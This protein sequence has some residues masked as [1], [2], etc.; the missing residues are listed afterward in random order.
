MF[1]SFQPIKLAGNH[2]AKFGQITILHSEICSQPDLQKGGATCWRKIW[3][4]V[5]QNSI[6]FS[7]FFLINSETTLKKMCVVDLVSSVCNNSMLMIIC[8]AFSFQK[9]K[10]VGS[11]ESKWFNFGCISK[12][13]K[14]LQLLNSFYHTDLSCFLSFS[15]RNFFSKAYNPGIFNLRTLMIVY[16]QHHGMKMS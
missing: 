10:L 11:K 14:M 13:K 7:P 16:C 5:K 9:K 3:A 2:L 12:E 6:F 8:H 1:W 15:H 4:K